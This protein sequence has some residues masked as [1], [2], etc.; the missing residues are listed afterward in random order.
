MLPDIGMGLTSDGHHHLLEAFKTLDVV[1]VTDTT[2]LSVASN[3]IK[4]NRNDQQETITG[5]EN[6]VVAC[7]ATPNDQLLADLKGLVNEVFLIGDAKE[8]RDALE[9]IHEGA[10]AARNL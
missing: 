4:V 8:P 1:P 3:E 9:A 6:V 7:G 10:E 2:V 5:I